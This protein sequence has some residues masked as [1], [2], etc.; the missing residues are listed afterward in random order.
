MIHETSRVTISGQGRLVR[1]RSLLQIGALGAIG[2]TLPNFL[3]WEA[4]AR[5]AGQVQTQARNA[6]LIFLGGGP[7]H[8]DTFDP[9]PD[10]PAEIRGAFGTVES[11][12]KGVRFSDSIPL[13]AA[14]MHRLAVLRAVSHRQSAHE[15]GVAYMT[16][17]YSF[18][19]G[20]NFPTVGAVVGYERRGGPHGLPPHVAV[21][22]G[23]G[24]GHLGPAHNALA[25]PGDPTDPAFRVQDL[26]PPDDA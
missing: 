23:G 8:L 12:V 1:R 20:H 11:S 24:S 14:Q 26:V 16:T 5:A 4:S 2:L 19:P 17:G 9:K 15:A 6:I 25:V 13:L 21:P 18:R 3:R 10:A 22:D 7:S